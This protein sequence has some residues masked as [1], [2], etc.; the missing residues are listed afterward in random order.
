MRTYPANINIACPVHHAIAGNVK[1]GRRKKNVPQ[2][3]FIKPVFYHRKVS[4]ET[5]ATCLHIFSPT[6]KL[7]SWLL[8]QRGAMGRIWKT[9]YWVQRRLHFLKG[10]GMPRCGVQ[11]TGRCRHKGGPQI[12]RPR[13]P[14]RGPFCVARVV[15]PPAR[16]GH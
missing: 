13:T 11:Q 12:Y 6:A 2:D 4:W 14:H 15:V 9:P 7:S 3:I 10:V 8:S 16:M 1:R 5:S